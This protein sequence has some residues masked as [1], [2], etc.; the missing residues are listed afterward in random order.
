[1]LE[2][3]S[4]NRVVACGEYLYRICRTQ[5]NSDTDLFGIYS[6]GRDY[7]YHGGGRCCCLVDQMVKMDMYV[8]NLSISGLVVV[9]HG[10][11]QRLHSQSIVGRVV[12]LAKDS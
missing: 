8:V 12:D 10:A 2:T 11:Y 4:W 3:Q 9:D 1:M 6:S 7:D 5:I